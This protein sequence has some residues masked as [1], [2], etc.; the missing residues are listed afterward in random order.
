[1]SV[2]AHLELELVGATVGEV[3]VKRMRLKL[4]HHESRRSQ[5]NM[6]V[7]DMHPAF[8][9]SLASLAPFELKRV[10]RGHLRELVDGG[11][12]LGRP[13]SRIE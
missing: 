13:T 7:S 12:E 3:S 9:L 8:P 6:D 2:R 1:M 4:S 11:P 10:P 5:I